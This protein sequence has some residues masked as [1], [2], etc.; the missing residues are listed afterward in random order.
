MNIAAAGAARPADTEDCEDGGSRTTDQ[1][2]VT[3]TVTFDG[4]RVS[5]PGIGSFQ[6]DGFIRVSLGF[7][8]ASVLFEFVVTDRSNGRVVDFD[9]TITAQPRIGGGFVVDGGPLSVRGAVE[10]PEIFRITFE[11]V[12]VDGENRILSGS[13]EAEDTSDSFDLKTVEVEVEDASTTASVHVVRDDDSA[14][15]YLL[16][17]ENGDLTPVD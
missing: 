11:D 14:R 10:G 16:N 1:A 3:V 2:G 4:C 6:F 7:P 9:G 5:E 8:N 13:L 12:T 17:L 15:E